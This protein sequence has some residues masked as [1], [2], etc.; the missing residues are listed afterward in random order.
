MSRSA[1]NTAQ[2]ATAGAGSSIG[3]IGQSFQS[4]S[5]P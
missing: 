4:R 3:M 1:T 5:S 2:S